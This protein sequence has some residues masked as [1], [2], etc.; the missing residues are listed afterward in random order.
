M[1]TGKFIYYNSII[2]MYHN[3]PFQFVLLNI[4]RL[5]SLYLVLF[6]DSF[7]Q[8]LSISYLIIQSK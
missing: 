5:L 3:I 7:Y 4:L 1:Y 8:E 2:G 6:V